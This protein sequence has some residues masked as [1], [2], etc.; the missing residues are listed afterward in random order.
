MATVFLTDPVPDGDLCGKLNIRIDRSGQWFYHDSPIARK[1]MVSLFSSIMERHKDGSYWL[2]TPG[3]RG[4]IDVEDVPFVGVELFTSGQGRNLVVSLRTNVD[5]VVTLGSEH[6]LR[7]GTCPTTGEAVPY[8]LVRA[9][10]EARLNRSVY[11]QLV[12]L[13]QDENINGE[14]LYGIWSDGIFFA[15]GKTQD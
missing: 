13:G 5:E 9:D 12:E 14:D 3:E 6:P 2:T 10:L 1:E 4:T 11:Y 8:F 15:L 7:M